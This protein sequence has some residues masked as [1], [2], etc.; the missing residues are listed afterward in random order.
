MASTMTIA[1]LE[2]AKDLD[3][4]VTDWVQIDQAMIEQ[5]ADATRDHQW[6]HV[7]HEK[8]AAGPFGGTIAHGFL[9]V[10]LLPELLGQLMTVEGS[11]M[12]V[13]YGMDR[14]RLTS[15]VPS[16]ARIR[17]RGRILETEPKGQ[18]ILVRTEMTIE[19]EGQDKPA[20]VGV[21]LTLRY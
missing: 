21:F 5:F 14:L 15:P 13:N 18:G 1:E 12:G 2:S 4:G 17:A 8:A 10:S 9:T 3:L 16:G 7:D 19:I 6:I 11:Q 20:M